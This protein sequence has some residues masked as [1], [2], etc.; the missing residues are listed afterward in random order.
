M[1]VRNLGILTAACCLHLDNRKYD[2]SWQEVSLSRTTR[3]VSFLYLPV[4][5]A[6]SRQSDGVTH[7]DAALW[8]GAPVQ[9]CRSSN[10]NQPLLHSRIK[11]LVWTRDRGAF[12]AGASSGST[13]YR[14]S[15]YC[16]LSA[17]QPTL[18]TYQIGSRS[19]ELRCRRWSVVSRKLAQFISSENLS[20]GFGP[21][22]ARPT[23][24]SCNSNDSL[25]AARMN[26]A[27]LSALGSLPK[28]P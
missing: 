12:L 4:I 2:C 28:W 13:C 22:L 19:A 3:L 11:R 15:F 20:I 23:Y 26:A 6:M 21:I 10:C 5:C 14:T 17:C 25:A 7:S 24:H 18:I 9:L 27:Q 16:R 8:P 1:N